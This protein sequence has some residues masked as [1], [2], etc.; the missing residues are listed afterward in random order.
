[1]VIVELHC[2]LARSFS[3]SVRL[4]ICFIVLLVD[5]SLTQH[6]TIWTCSPCPIFM[7]VFRYLPLT[8]HWSSLL[9]CTELHCYLFSGFI[10]NNRL[11][12]LTMLFSFPCLLFTGCVIYLVLSEAWFSD[13]AVSR[14]ITVTI[15]TKRNICS[16]LDFAGFAENY[17]IE[18]T[19]VFVLLSL[20]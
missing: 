18:V 7:S 19:N 16:D 5:F 2:L 4:F 8:P 15:T 1:M 3:I 13:L 17:S 14:P 20:I 11:L 12:L 6:Q 10:W 9:K